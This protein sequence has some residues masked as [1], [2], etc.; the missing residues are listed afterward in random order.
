MQIAGIIL[1][2]LLFFGGFLLAQ[3]IF[4]H[5]TGR[6]FWRAMVP[7]SFR[8][9][10]LPRD[11]VQL[12]SFMVMEEYAALLFLGAFMILPLIALSVMGFL[13]LF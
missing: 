2:M 11:G 6:T 7:A 1:A 8:Y 3:A 10:L 9:T 5:H 12:D 13:S 4:F